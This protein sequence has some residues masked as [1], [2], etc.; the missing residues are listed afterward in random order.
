[1]RKKNEEHIPENFET[2]FND[3]SG[4]TLFLKKLNG[5]KFQPISAEEEK[6]LCRRRDAGD[7][8][9]KRELASHNIQW[10]LNISR[11]NAP[12][13]IETDDLIQTAF[14]GALR[15]TNSFDPEK[16]RMT[17]HM[18]LWVRQTINK[19]TSQSK[20]L[21]I[22]KNVL[23][24]LNRC[25]YARHLLKNQTSKNPSFEAIAQ[26]S[27]EIYAQN[28][29]K[30][31]GIEEPTKQQVLD[32]IETIKE[33]KN[34][35]QIVDADTVRDLINTIEGRANNYVQISDDG[36]TDDLLNLVP[37][38]TPMGA[39]VLAHLF[40]SETASRM[41]NA[42]NKEERQVIDLSF[43]LG[44][45]FEESYGVEMSHRDICEK[46]N[47]TEVRSRSIKTLALNRLRKCLSE[48]NFEM[49]SADDF[50]SPEI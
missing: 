14:E 41:L 13:D 30:K 1:M 23:S 7:P 17:T 22:P 25:L 16:G 33:S 49:A 43:G 21:P 42:L 15:A 34:N 47:I 27:N 19:E 50:S 44:I 18:P 48:S 8:M 6:E 9:A 5:P 31:R 10:A 24:N 29:L 39:D 40:N 3:I 37:S 4:T 38:E 12:K 46:L 2:G 26:L 35:I 11:K 20:D 45:E 32:T 28:T 36:E